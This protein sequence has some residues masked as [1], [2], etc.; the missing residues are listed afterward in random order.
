MNKIVRKNNWSLL[1]KALFVFVAI[2]SATTIFAQNNI[3]I[4][5]KIT[6]ETGNTMPG[7]TVMVKGTSIGGVSDANG[8][9]EVIA[10]DKNSVLVFSYLGYTTKD[11]TVGNQSIINVQMKENIQ[12]MDEVVVIGY[13]AVKR[14]DVTG[15]VVSV[16]TDEMM[17]RN[18]LTV[19][20][21]LQGAAA[22]VNVFRNSGSPSGDITIRILGVGTVNNSADPLFVVDG[23]QVG[24]DISFLNPNDI[25]NIEILKDASA[26]AIYGARGANGVILVTTKKGFKGQT[27]LT[28]SAN[29]NILTNSKS[30]DVLKAQ[31]FVKMAQ[32]S[33]ANDKTTLTNTAWTQNASQLNNID[34]QNAMT[35]TA[36]QQNYNLSVS[37]GGENSQ[38]ILS[39]GYRNNDGLLIASN[40]QRFTARASTDYKIKDFIRTGININFNYRQSYGTGNSNYQNMINVATSIPT[41]DA[42]VNNQFYNVPI[43]WNKESDN[44]YKDGIWGHYIREANG[45]VPPGTDNPVAAVRTAQDYGGGSRIFTSAYLEI[46]LLKGLTFRTVDGFTY[47]SGYYNSYSPVNPRTFNTNGQPDQ[48]YLSNSSSKTLSSEN[49]LTYNW[50]INPSNRLNLMAG[51]S[52]SASNG[53]WQNI[54]SKKF[55]VP[56]VRQISLSQD[57]STLTGDGALNRQ[58]R[59]QSFFGR[60]IYSLADRYVITGTV[61]RDGS[62]NFGA[63]NRYGTFPS[64]SILWRASEEKFMKNQNILSK[65]NLRLGWGRVG[66]A[67]NSTNLSVDQLSSN[68]ITYYFYNAGGINPTPI[69]APGL[70]QTQI[71]DTNL[72]W[73]TNESKNVSLEMGFLKNTITAGVEYFVRDTKDLLLYRNVRPSTGYSSVY[74]NAGAIR[75]SGFEFFATYEKKVGDWSYS[76]KLN[77]STLKNKVIDVG[78]PIEST[79]GAGTSEGWDGWSRTM[80]GYPIATFYGY[81]VAGIFQSQAEIDAA[82]AAAKAA[83]SP[84]G[85]YQG[86]SVRPGDFKFKDL[87]GNGYVSDLDR[88]PLGNGF[89]KLNYG[90][91]ANISYK[92]WDLNIFLYGI[93]GQ[94][95]MSYSYKTLTTANGGG[96]HNILQ[97]SYDKAWRPDNPSAVFPLISNKDQN[98]NNNQRVSDFYVKNGDFLRIQN[99]QIGY[100]FSKKLISS[101]K[102]E[103]ARLYASIENL[104]TITGYKGGDPEI[105]GN[106]KNNGDSDNGILRTGFDNGR[107]P[108]PRMFVLGFSIGF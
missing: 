106:L 103:N 9:Y 61:R 21:G 44:P 50:K 18:P 17:K 73:E 28:F 81:R 43:R 53:Q 41:M 99:I 35:R 13:G 25:E 75:N 42:I 93:A 6:D 67:G 105:G 30:Y 85:T 59:G 60:A 87:D 94:Q 8:S 51:W 64:A 16:N 65:L 47:N 22:G 91:N 77:G 82:N 68:R 83:G 29:Y 38:S 23:I 71:I 36:L 101:L 90:L 19:G 63:G 5:G 14:S 20:E 7:V 70:A 55:P 52:V 2:I 4:S 98:K 3:K 49:Y 79:D 54:S 24:T 62:S 27:R 1:R 39:I 80:N 95:I 100:T 57:L 33:A 10:P 96:Y 15:S 107:Y 32:E 58:D 46:D 104:A 12:Q 37:G 97:E 11:V 108:F 72:K 26:A 48:F 31:D 89:P 102:M 74:T 88:E 92:N 84:N 45:D 86:Q 56:S 40:F 66:N 78:N 69:T 76:I 34:W